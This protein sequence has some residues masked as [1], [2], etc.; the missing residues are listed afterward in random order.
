MKVE[1]YCPQHL[2]DETLELSDNHR[3][4]KGEVQ[5][6]PGQGETPHTL[7]VWFIRGFL[8]DVHAVEADAQ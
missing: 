3:Y 8:V 6:S 1:F 7:K 5:C 2:K 4:F